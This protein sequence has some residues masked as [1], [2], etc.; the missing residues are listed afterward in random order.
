MAIRLGLIREVV[1][2]AFDTVRANKMR[3]GLT[4][5]GVVIG[6]TSIVGMTAMIRGF[7][8]SLRDMISVTGPNIIYLQRF[9]IASFINGTELKELFKRPDL[10]I[11]DAR[12]LE[13]AAPSLQYVDVELGAGPG[14]I[15][16]QRVFYRTLKTKPVIVFGTSE[17]F[18]EGTRIPIAA[19]RFFNGTELQYRKNVVVLGYTAYSL[20]FEST[21]IDPTGKF[22]RVGSERFEVV[23]AFDKRPSAGGFNLNL[24]DFVVI[25]YTS[26][27]RIY[28]LKVGR[29]NRTATIV[30]VQISILPREGVSTADAMA[31]VQRVM[32]IRH[33]LKLDQPDDF[34]MSTQDQLLKLWDRI[35]EGTFFGLIVISS[36]ALMVG[37]IGVMAI[38]S[39]SVTERTR[40]IGVRKALGARRAEILLQFL[41]EAGVLTSVGGVI[42]IALGSALGWAVH[43]L[44][45]F[46]ISLPWWSFA[47]GLGFSLSVGVFFGMYP[48]FKA[49]RL[50]PIEALRYE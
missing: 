17:Y 11:S 38:M 30:N 4:V 44:S 34:D 42:G 7:D 26:Y 8:Q 22:V 32:R 49:S 20:L 48:A 37:G 2:M 21:G 25:P 39:I 27:Q 5:L 24:D 40:E 3:S 10:K 16:Q 19:G 36:I 41:T 9:G 45:G 23:G 13:E 18:A 50:D 28:G 29:I 1:T 14:P 33:G 46:P 6:I 35:S 47:I 12:A 31:D 43:M 15:S